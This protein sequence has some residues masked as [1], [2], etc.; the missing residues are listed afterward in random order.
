MKKYKFIAET[1]IEAKNEDQ[2]KG[3]FADSSFD[4][5]SNAECIEVTEEKSL[6]DR[7]EE[8][9]AILTEDQLLEKYDQGIIDEAREYE[10]S[11]LSSR[12]EEI[13]DSIINL[14]KTRIL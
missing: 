4:F 5:A 7:L 11:F 8:V 3:I 12:Y 9:A 6:E 14:I 13:K 1:T 10:S 2:A